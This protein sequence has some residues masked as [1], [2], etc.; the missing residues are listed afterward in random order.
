MSLMYPELA[1]RFFIS[2]NTWDDGYNLDLMW[3]SFHY[4]CIKSLCCTLKGNTMLYVNYISF[5]SPF[6]KFILFK[7]S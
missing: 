6:L 5:V 1:G 2:S 3:G 7:Y 4:T